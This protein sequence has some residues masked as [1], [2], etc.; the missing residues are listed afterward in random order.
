MATQ[1]GSGPVYCWS[2]SGLIRRLC[3]R[4]PKP[5]GGG[6]ACRC[7]A[8]ISRN[9]SSA[10]PTFR[11]WRTAV[12]V[13]EIPTNT[14]GN[15]PM[16]LC[17]AAWTELARRR[18]HRAAESNVTSTVCSSCGRNKSAAALSLISS[19]KATTCSTCASVPPKRD[20]RQSGRRLKVT[21]QVRQYQ[22]ATSA[23]S[24][25][26]AYGVCRCNTHPPWGRRGQQ[27]S[28]ASSHPCLL[29]YSSLDSSEANRSCTAPWPVRRQPCGPSFLSACPMPARVRA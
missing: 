10:A 22:R 3:G 2:G 29:M 19:R 15:R 25:L 6:K 4:G 18:T 9:A 14:P 8:A 13:G 27:S 21:W 7:A 17:R 1:G 26:R 24:G 12:T 20:A 16:I 23:P 28:L 5:S 11:C